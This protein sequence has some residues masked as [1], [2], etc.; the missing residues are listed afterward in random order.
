[1][2]LLSRHEPDAVVVDRSD[3]IDWGL[4]VF[5]GVVGASEYKPG[6]V[7]CELTRTHLA[8]VSV[9]SRRIRL[10]SER[11]GWSHGRRHL[12]LR[13]HAWRQRWSVDGWPGGGLWRNGLCVTGRRTH[14][15]GGR[16]EGR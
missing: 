4:Y 1:M 7:Q 13:R 8:E 11:G 15:G 12:R 16:R 10:R 5:T 3:L 2:V 6:A 9:V 14:R